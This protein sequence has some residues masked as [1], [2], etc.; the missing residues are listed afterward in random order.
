MT[1]LHIEITDEEKQRLEQLAREHGFETPEA[2]IKALLLE[3]TKAE[4][5]ND[6]R[7]GLLAAQRG[8]PMPTLDQ[9]WA[10]IEQANDITIR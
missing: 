4:L 8:D 7:E 6:I 2:Y 5:L 10:E 1:Y 9:M 3:P